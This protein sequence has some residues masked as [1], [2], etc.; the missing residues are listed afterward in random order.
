MGAGAFNA[1]WSWGGGVEQSIERADRGE[2]GRRAVHGEKI[3]IIAPSQPTLV[4]FSR[5]STRI[6]NCPPSACPTACLGLRDSVG[7]DFG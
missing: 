2:D 7:V 4:S 3:R 1:R 6:C 5:G